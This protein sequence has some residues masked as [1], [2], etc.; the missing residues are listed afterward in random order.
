[1][2]KFKVKQNRGAKQEFPLG[3]PLYLYSP[4]CAAEEAEGPVPAPGL[5]TFEGGTSLM[6]SM[7]EPGG[8]GARGC[9]PKKNRYKKKKV[10]RSKAWHDFFSILI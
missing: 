7:L 5:A 3:F 4:D 10:Y 2:L 8:S 6:V 1:M 9:L